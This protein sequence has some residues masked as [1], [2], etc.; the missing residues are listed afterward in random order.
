MKSTIKR[1]TTIVQGEFLLQLKSHRL[2]ATYLTKNNHLLKMIFIN[3]CQ[4][5]K[6]P[7]Y[8]LDWNIINIIYLP[9]STEIHNLVKV[10]RSNCLIKSHSIMCM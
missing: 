5:N 8:N 2:K 4:V 10:Q 1:F 6:R 3:H 9:L 7:I